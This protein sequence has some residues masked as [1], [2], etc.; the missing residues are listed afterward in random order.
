M[1]GYVQEKEEEEG[2]NNTKGVRARK[3]RDGRNWPSKF[4]NVW[5]CQL[6]LCLV[7]KLLVF[8]RVCCLCAPP[9]LNFCVVVCF[10]IGGV[11]DVSDID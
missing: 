5:Y 6:L 11:V 2:E 3:R 7:V 1:M 4:P 10:I 8:C 9:T